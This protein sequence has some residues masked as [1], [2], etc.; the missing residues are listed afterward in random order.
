[1]NEKLKQKLIFLAD[2]YEISSFCDNDPSQFLRWYD[3]ERIADVEVASFIA[4]MLSFGN[5]KQ[6]IPKIKSILKLADSFVDA[7]GKSLGVAKWIMQGAKNFPC[8]KEKFY[9]FYSYDDLHCLFGEMAEIL[10]K[11]KTLGD[12]F[13]K[14]WSGR[15][16]AVVVGKSAP[17]EGV[18]EDSSNLLMMAGGRGRLSP[19]L[20]DIIGQAFPNAKIVPKGRNSANKRIHM[21]LRWMV[22][23]NSSVDAGL[24]TWYGC[25]NLLLPLDTHVM[26]EAI[27]L[28]LLPKN[29]SATRKTAE[30]LT[31]I[32]EE[33]FPNDPARA[34]FAL[35][36][37]GV[38]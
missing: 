36:G 12:F 1:M 37:S 33:V 15:C 35:F 24:W 31:K 27:E 2:K 11:E 26:Q 29:A 30:Q 10:R 22:R 25:E 14:M 16:G 20:C 32:M 5:R 9:R 8:G 34:D 17:L 18:T 38:E 7:E 3:K 19:H 13:N 28:G 21:F 4:A 23:Q 6:F